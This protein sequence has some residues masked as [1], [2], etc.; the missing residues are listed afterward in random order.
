MLSNQ[1]KLK[2]TLPIFENFLQIFRFFAGIPFLTPCL[3]RGKLIH[4]LIFE[5]WFKLKMKIQT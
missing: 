1:E 3:W 2:A 5:F 4:A